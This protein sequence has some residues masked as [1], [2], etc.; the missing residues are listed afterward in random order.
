MINISLLGVSITFAIMM[1][2][3]ISFAWNVN[4]T[5]E[6]NLKELFEK[7]A[8]KEETQRQ[9]SE[10]EKQIINKADRTELKKMSDQICY[11]HNNFDKILD[12]IIN[13]K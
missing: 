5:R 6:K 13:K 4:K 8:D 3:F 12:Y 9:F 1:I 11:I 2:S 7:K 10:L